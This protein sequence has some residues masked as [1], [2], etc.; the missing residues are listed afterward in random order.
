MKTT[1][2]TVLIMMVAFALLAGTGW[3]EKKMSKSGFLSDYSKLE[4]GKKGQAEFVYFKEG[5]NWK[6]YDKIMIDYLVFYLSKDAQD[7]G[8]QADELKEMADVWHMAFIDAVKEDYEIVHE[9]GPGVLRFRAAITDL[10]PTK[11]TLNTITSVVPVGLAFSILKKG[12]TGAGT[13]VGKVTSEAEILDSSTN[14]VLLQVIDFKAGEKYRVDKMASKWGHIRVAIES[15][16]K[17][18]HDGLEEISG[19][20]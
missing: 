8:I 5:V 13:G 18:L 3:A 10:S 4:E 6:S 11:R 2:R 7:K 17:S 12:V 15:W 1:L 16:A 20:K 14:D 19:K 9:P